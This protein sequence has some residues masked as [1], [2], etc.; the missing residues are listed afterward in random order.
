[1]ES[2]RRTGHPSRTEVSGP[3]APFADGFRQELA[4]KGYHPQVTGRQV[5]LMADLSS[6]LGG[7]GP[8]W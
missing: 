6:W 4:G 5:R 3:L 2:R 1:M 8:L 7:P